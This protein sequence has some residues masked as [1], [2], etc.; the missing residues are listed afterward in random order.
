MLQ[1][2]YALIVAGG[3]GSRM[4]ASIPKQFLCLNGLPL[5]MHTLN[6]FYSILP[7]PEIYLALPQT[8]HSSWAKLCNEYS[9]QVPH[10]V[11]AGGDTRFHSVKNGLSAI[12][13]DGLVAIHDGVR[14][15]V[16]SLLLERCYSVAEQEGN[17]I[18]A[19]R[20][21]ESIRFGDE[22]NSRKENREQVWLVQTPQVFNLKQITECYKLEWQP[23]FTDDASVAEANGY[24]IRIVEGER[25][26]IKITTP[27]DLTIANV[28]LE[29]G[30][31][32]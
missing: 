4:G 11:I 2:R 21:V 18:P 8:E 22:L 28:I 25:D 26:N 17:A 5:L 12:Q 1:R 30:G 23:H 13:G 24:R 16:S 31:K 10:T 14:P 20:P 7:K 27:I 3:S 6:A 32:K 15:L 29:R 19:L 9:F